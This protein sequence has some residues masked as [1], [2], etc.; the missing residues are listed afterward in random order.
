[1][2]KITSPAKYVG[3]L[4]RIWFR[5]LFFLMSSLLTVMSFYGL[6]VCS[7]PSFALLCTTGCLDT[8]RGLRIGYCTSVWTI[9][10]ISGACMD[11]DELRLLRRGNHLAAERLESTE[12]IFAHFLPSQ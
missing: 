9:M 5:I 4:G 11:V 3:L 1:M 7:F 10:S 2:I 6:F 8:L 12:L